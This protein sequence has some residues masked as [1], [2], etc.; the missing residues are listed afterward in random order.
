MIRRLQ[1]RGYRA[2]RAVD[3]ELRDFQVL[4]GPNA[5]GKTTLFD[6]LL[7]L[8]DIMRIVGVEARSSRSCV[9]MRHSASHRVP[10]T[11]RISRGYA[12]A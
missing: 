5:S 7:L 10:A 12:G 3:V 6:V 11:P 2:L 1:V 9:A 8:R 4:V